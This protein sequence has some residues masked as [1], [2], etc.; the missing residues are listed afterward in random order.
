VTLRSVTGFVALAWVSWRVVELVVL[1]ASARAYDD[2]VDVYD[3]VAGRV[4]VCV[5][6]FALLFHGLD[7]A[8]VAVADLVPSTA[9]FEPV[10]RAA[11]RFG[12]FALGIPAAAVVLWPV[13]QDVLR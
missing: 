6:L 4:T 7:G 12:T 1:D 10:T 5:V 9:R 11:A 8:R 2:L 13:V 3:G